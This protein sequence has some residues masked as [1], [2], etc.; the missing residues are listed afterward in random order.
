MATCSLAGLSE[1][2]SWRNGRAIDAKAVNEVSR[3]TNSDA[4][5]SATGATSSDARASEAKKRLSRVSGSD[6]L[7]ATGSRSVSSGTN[8]SIARLTSWPRPGEAAAE[9]VE[10]VARPHARLV[11]E[12]VEQLVE[13]DDGRTRLANRDRGAG[14]QPRAALARGELDVLEA[15]G[16]ARAHE[17]GRVGRHRLDLLV[18][19]HRDLRVCRPVGALARLDLRDEAHARAADADL[20]ALHQLR[21]VRQ[22]GLQVVGR[23]ERQAR[24]SR[25]RRGR[26]RRSSR[27]PSRRPRAPGWR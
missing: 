26:R 27:A 20:E 15:E 22:V 19:L 16:G 18:E 5:S 14:G 6:R 9:A 17:Q 10:R 4:C 12:H 2:V 23:H 21:R 8:A 7:R 25:C 24:S 13:L 11:V 3:F 1:I